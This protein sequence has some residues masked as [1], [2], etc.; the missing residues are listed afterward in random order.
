MIRFAALASDEAT[1]DPIDLVALSAARER[2]ISLADFTVLRFV[3]FDLSTKCSEALVRRGAEITRIVK[4]APSAIAAL[5]GVPELEEAGQLA[6]AGY[7]VLAV[8]AGKAQSMSPVGFLALLD[9]PRD[10]SARLIASLHNLGVRVVMIT[11]D[12]AETAR[13]IAAQVGI[14][15]EACSRERLRADIDAAAN[16]CNVFAGVFPENKFHLVQALQRA[17]HVAGMTGDGVNDA[18]A[19]KQAEVGVAVATATDVAK[20]AASIVLTN[21]GL[22][23]LVSAIETSRRIYQRMLTYTLN[24]IIKTLE[25][26]LFL[27]LGVVLTRTLI[28]SPL[29]IVLLLFTNDFVTMS[30]ATDRV[31][32]SQLP[33]R[34]RIRSLMLTALPL[35]CLLVLFSLSVLFVGWRVLGLGTREIQTLAFLTLVFGGQGTV[36]LVRERSHLWRSRPSRWMLLSSGIDLL[37]VSALAARGVLMAPLRPVLIVSLLAAVMLYL[38]VV[39]YLKIAIFRSFKVA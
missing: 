17:G 12:S 33:E 3:P 4:G 10:D 7:R 16:A 11:G 30:I 13:A 8:A 38:F 21:P 25:I 27:T 20:A 5:V 26:A 1:Q 31:G 34:W 36:Y 22:G 37:I 6:R 19:L 29:L 23:E 24:K 32:F 2:S 39:D 14:T 18:P 15:G 9:P 28:I 35:A